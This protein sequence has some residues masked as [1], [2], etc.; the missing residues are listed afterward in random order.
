MIRRGWFLV[1]SLGVTVVVLMA[2]GLAYLRTQVATSRLPERGQS[3]QR[4]AGCPALVEILF[5]ASGAPHVYSGSDSALWFAQGYL[6]AKDRFFQMDLARRTANGRLAELFG[7]RALDSDRKM[8]I[9]RLAPSAR[10]QV[11]LLTAHERRVLELYTEGVNAA[12]EEYGSWIAPEVWLLGV[13]PERWSIEDSLVSGLFFQLNSSPAMGQEMHRA[14]MLSRLGRDRAV[15]LWGWTR[16][17]AQAWVPPGDNVIQPVR[18][19]EP[20]SGPAA[21]IGSNAWVISKRRSASGRAL[22]AA[23]ANLSV[24]MPSTFFPIHLSGPGL[25]VAGVSIAGIPGVVVGHTREV[26]WSLTS[27]MMDDQDLFVLT[28]DDPGSRELI[29]GRWRPLRTVTENISVRWQSDP[30]LVKV[31]LSVHGPVVRNQRGDSL[32]LAWSGVSGPSALRAILGMNRAQT[33][34]GAAESWESIVSPSMS[35]LAADTGGTILHQVVG[36]IPERLR[37][38]GRL[39]APGSDSN[40]AWKGFMPIAA[41][42]RKVDPPGGFLVLAGHDLFAEGDYPPSQAFPAE[43]A[44]PWRARRIKTVL[45]KRE[46]WTVVGCVDLLSDLISTEAIAVLKQLRPDLERHGGP[47]ARELMAWDAKMDAASNAASLYSRFMLDLGDAI[48]G[49]EAN[50]LSLARVPLDREEILRLLAGGLDESWWDDVS[51]EGRQTKTEVLENL[52]DGLDGESEIGRWGEVHQVLFTHPLTWIPG[53]GSLVAA[54]WN[55]GPFPIGGDRSTVHTED[56][57][58]REPFAVTS[59]PA[60]RF[61][62][63]VGNWDATVLGLPTGQS[64]RPWSGHYADQIESWLKVDPPIFP[65]SREAVEAAATARLQLVPQRVRVSTIE[66]AQ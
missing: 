16:A 15:D 48:G 36:R 14:V 28:L 57:S 63:E 8:R 23:D 25:E 20:I 2:L 47:V 13:E 53:A 1:L 32:A 45:A 33:A 41:N 51:L 54:T 31:R 6:H 60:M 4:I 64:G 5:D 34:F 11:A 55:R 30:V 24:Q 56:W 19:H 61:V 43:F 35:L 44:P 59:L 9:L 46:A 22:L 40:W 29:D 52:L 26:A 38:A 21:E 17:E 18:E 3:L 37:G 50:R 49:D 7:E 65:F 66:A 27:S 12:I 10:R 58:R 62:T 39:P 42:P